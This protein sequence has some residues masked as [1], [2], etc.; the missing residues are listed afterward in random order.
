MSGDSKSLTER[1]KEGSDS[2]SY[3]HIFNIL[4]AVLATAPEFNK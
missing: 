4:K 2:D 1:T 3:E